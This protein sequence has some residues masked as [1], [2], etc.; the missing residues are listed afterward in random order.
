MKH[1]F[2]TIFVPDSWSGTEREWADL[3][4]DTYGFD[5]DTER[6]S[7]GGVL[8]WPCNDEEKE[9]DAVLELKMEL[10]DDDIQ[11]ETFEATHETM[12][13]PLQNGE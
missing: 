7:A 5:Y 6:C 1:T 3:H 13:G 10:D 4:W 9:E 12:F 8:A 2:F 11:Y